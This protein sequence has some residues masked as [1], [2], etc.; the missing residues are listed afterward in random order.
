MQV[1]EPLLA[2][3]WLE[4]ALDEGGPSPALLAR[5]GDAA[6]RGGDV[7]RARTAVADGLQLAPDDPALLALGRRVAIDPPRPEGNRQGL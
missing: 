6:W 4:R 5:L 7:A 2:V 1:G 3:R